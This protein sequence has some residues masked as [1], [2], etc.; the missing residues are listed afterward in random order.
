MNELSLS[1]SVPSSVVEVKELGY[2]YPNASVGLGR[3]TELPAV[4]GVNLTLAAGGSLGVVGE[5][6][7]GKSS[8]A[9]LVMGL[10]SPGSGS[11]RIHGRR[12]DQL[13]GRSLRE[14]RREIQMIFQDPLASLHP[15]Y[16]VSA[17][18]EEPLRVH[19]VS[20]EARRLTMESW[21]ERV[22]LNLRVGQRYPYELSGGER[23]RVCLA[24]ALVLEPSILV[25]DEPVASLDPS[26]R[27]EI[28]QLLLQLQQ[29]LG[30]ALLVISHDV[31][32]IRRLADHIAVMFAGRIVEEGPATEVLSRPS[33]PYTLELLEAS[34]I[35]GGDME[36][37]QSNRFE[38]RVRTKVLHGAGCS[39][40]ARCRYSLAICENEVPKKEQVG[41]DHR[42]ECHRAHEL[43]AGQEP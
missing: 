21:L 8:L 7:S 29:E 2:S 38:S 13:R 27:A 20:V 42:S 5:S 9:R 11:I 15:R 4:D 34:G 41:R 40:R 32:A 16:R 25:A 43:G 30:M 37:Q 22:G 19:G 10:E 23:Q 31:R 14:A 18:I 12:L 6:G 3:R 24:R 36:D 17:L 1:D 28:L 26:R 39:F 35:V 33:H